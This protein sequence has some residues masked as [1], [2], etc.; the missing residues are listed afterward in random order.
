MNMFSIYSIPS[1][2]FFWVFLLFLI[3]AIFVLTV[4]GTVLLFPF[5]RQLQ[6][7]PFFIRIAL[8][9]TAGI[10]FFSLQSF[11]LGYLNIRFM[12]WPFLIAL[13]FI[14]IYKKWFLFI[15]PHIKH[16]HIT[17]FS[18]AIGMLFLFGVLGQVM[19][20]STSGIK[21][22]EGLLFWGVNITDGQFLLSLA[23][24][25][26]EHFPPQQPGAY[27]IPM[28]NY[29]YLSALVEG[30]FSRIFALPL[31][32]LHFHLF[33][34][35]LSLLL[36]LTGIFLLQQMTKKQTALLWMLVVLYFSGD[37]IW[38]VQIAAG[39]PIDAA[40]SSLEDGVTFLLNTPRAYSIPLLFLFLG[41]S[42]L[43]N[44]EKF[45]KKTRRELFWKGLSVGL[46]AG[47]I[48]GFKIYTGIFVLM[49][50]GTLFLWSSIRNQRIWIFAAMSLCISVAV[51]VLL[52]LAVSDGTSKL[53]FAPFQL[54]RSFIVQPGLALDRLEHIRR[55]AL[56]HSRFDRVLLFD[57]FFMTLFLVGII[58]IRLIGFSTL[59]LSKIRSN[60]P[61]VLL[62]IF[63][64]IGLFIVGS[65]FLQHPGNQNSFNFFVTPM[66]PLALLSAVAINEIFLLIKRFNQVALFLFFGLIMAAIFPRS[67]FHYQEIYERLIH[68]TPPEL[69][70]QGEL[71]ALTFLRKK[72]PPNSTVFIT[73][74]HPVDRESPFAR[75]YANRPMVFSG[76]GILES[77]GVVL[78]DLMSIKTAIE[79]NGEPSDIGN[80]MSENGITYLYV[81][82][83]SPPV[84]AF[85][86]RTDYPLSPLSIVYQNPDVAIIECCQEAHTP[87]SLPLETPFEA[88]NFLHQ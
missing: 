82:R 86:R 71:Q 68:K 18:F 42:L 77:H 80:L 9:T 65:L 4:P 25:L 84:P 53:F 24:E 36:G 46:I 50:I 75:F 62:L 64:S 56:A 79:R 73:G 69:V 41:L 13:L 37:L 67:L 28:K 30:E 66:F 85:L 34:P 20:F 58:G 6:N 26:A 10:S 8:A 11:A 7:Q 1:I 44:H 3:A 22:A 38:L 12:A 47:S 16:I 72:T 63:P 57:G 55:E 5:H 29:H 40:M 49:G 81:Y 27:T 35:L 23:A 52:Y 14:V 61:I 39:K 17:Y 31:L 33:G 43:T 32:H 45:Q 87:A 2:E 70:G 74:N 88:V 48:V 19:N 78:N 76:R 59:F 21:T 15:L 60:A 54:S 83:R 51:T